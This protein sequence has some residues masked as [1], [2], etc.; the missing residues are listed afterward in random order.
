MPR[1]GELRQVG[2]AQAHYDQE[3]MDVSVQRFPA[4]AIRGIHVV[5]LAERAWARPIEAAGIG[6]QVAVANEAACLG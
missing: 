2:R 4:L 3:P 5:G 6:L 1:K